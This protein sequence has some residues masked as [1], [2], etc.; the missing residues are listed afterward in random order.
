MK[1]KIIRG[2][3]EA[4]EIWV[5]KWTYCKTQPLANGHKVVTLMWSWLL[6]IPDLSLSLGVGIC[7]SLAVK[8]Q[9]HLEV[10]SDSAPGR[11]KRMEPI[12]LNWTTA[13]TLLHFSI[14]NPL[15]DAYKGIALSRDDCRVHYWD[16]L[17]LC[18][19]SWNLPPLHPHWEESQGLS[20]ELLHPTRFTGHLPCLRLCARH[21]GKNK[22]LSLYRS[23]HFRTSLHV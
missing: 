15:Q 16:H 11:N 7:C 3:E 19:R 4:N 23:P 6:L 2:Q 12:S 17:K 13:N 8:Q 21:M 20:K 9:Y 14:Y 5:P 1:I 18:F 22:L 10:S